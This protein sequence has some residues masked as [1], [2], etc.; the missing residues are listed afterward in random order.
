VVSGAASNA[1]F[2]VFYSAGSATTAVN[3]TVNDGN[4][5]WVSLGKHAITQ[6][7]AGQKVTRTQN[8]GGKVVADAVKI[9]RDTTGITNTSHHSFTYSYDPTANQ[10]GIADNSTR[11]PRS[12]ATR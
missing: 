10:T 6:A 5:G 7:D 11:P 2:K 4:G 12:P 3:Q 8:T 1:S 9:V